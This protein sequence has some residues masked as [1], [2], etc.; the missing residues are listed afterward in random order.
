M[1]TVTSLK[2]VLLGSS[3]VG[4]SS[5]GLR[6][7]ENR[8]SDESEPTLGAAFLSKTISVSGKRVKFT[9][10]DT[11]GQERY[12]AIAKMYYQDAQAAILV[13]DITS[14]ESFAD[15]KYWYRELAEKGPADISRL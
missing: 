5:L 1:A 11:A 12:R 3:G 6:F 14:K 9:I 15:L 7:T 13:Y 2:I 8:F 10:W 4:K